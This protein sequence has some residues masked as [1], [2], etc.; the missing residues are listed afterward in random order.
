METTTIILNQQQIDL[1]NHI[2]EPVAENKG[3]RYS[4]SAQLIANQI[5]LKLV[6]T[7]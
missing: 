7:D 4:K 5:L 3:T 1:L 2:L 6:Y